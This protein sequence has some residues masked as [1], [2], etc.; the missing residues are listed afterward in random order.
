MSILAA[1]SPKSALCQLLPV[2]GGTTPPFRDCTSGA[3]SWISN[4]VRQ[5]LAGVRE[6]ISAGRR[7]S[8]ELIALA[9]EALPQAVLQHLGSATT[10]SLQP[11]INATGVILHSNLGRAPW[12]NRLSSA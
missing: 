2:R 1:E 11:V 9:I 12:R 5:A 6:D 3:S 7:D 8:S 10:F 4:A